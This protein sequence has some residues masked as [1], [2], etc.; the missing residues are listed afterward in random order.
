MSSGLNI[1][2]SAIFPLTPGD[3]MSKEEVQ[4]SLL[5]S[6]TVEVRYSDDLGL[7]ED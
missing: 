6:V 4:G 1:L 3:Y 5:L 7:G 2:K